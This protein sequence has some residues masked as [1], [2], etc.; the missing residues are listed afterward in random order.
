MEDALKLAPAFWEWFSKIV[1]KLSENLK[2]HDIL[3]ELDQRILALKSGRLSWEVGPGTEQENLL[4]ISPSGDEQ[5]LE[6]TKR[7][8]EFA[9]G[10][11]GWEFWPAKLPKKSWSGQF[12][13]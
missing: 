6:F 4:V 3:R 5:L 11:Q 9:P 10:I 12:E 8:V 13:F 7:F 1:D 2:N